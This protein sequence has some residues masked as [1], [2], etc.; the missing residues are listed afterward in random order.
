[1]INEHMIINIKYNKFTNLL[2]QWVF[3]FS[4][5][6]C[7]LRKDLIVLGAEGLNSVNLRYVFFC[8]HKWN[9]A[10]PHKNVDSNY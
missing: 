3:T 10:L 4:C 1:M 9:L 2:S 6:M 5:D 7:C 8:D